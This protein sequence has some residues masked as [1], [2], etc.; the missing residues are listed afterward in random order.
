MLRRLY[1][2]ASIFLLERKDSGS[3]AEEDEGDGDNEGA[4]VDYMSSSDQER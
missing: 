2:N 4:E 1:F 3:E